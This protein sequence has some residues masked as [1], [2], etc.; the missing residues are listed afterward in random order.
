MPLAKL[1]LVTRSH[2]TSRDEIRRTAGK[3]AP[4]T[5]RAKRAHAR[6][7]QWSQTAE[8]RTVASGSVERPHKQGG[9]RFD[10]GPEHCARSVLSGW[11]LLV[12]NAEWSAVAA[13]RAR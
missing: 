3:T 4:R 1:W 8:S 13:E 9:R 11:C 10:S 5:R 7:A 2:W 12:C 6:V